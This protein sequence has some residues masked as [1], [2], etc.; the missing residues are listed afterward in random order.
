MSVTCQPVSVGIRFGLAVVA[1]LAPGTA[2]RAEGAAASLSVTNVPAKGRGESI[3]TVSRFGRYAV[4]AESKQGTALQL[5][6]RMLGPGEIKGER[7]KAN[8]RIDAILDRGTYKV[9]TWSHKKGTGK[10]TLKVHDFKELNAKPPALIDYKEVKATLEDFQQ[11]SYWIWVTSAQ[12]VLIEAVGRDLADLRLWKD[13]EWL[14]D[15][16]PSIETTQPVVGR[17]LTN[18]K[19]AVQLEPGLYLVTAYGGPGLA[20]A[21]ESREHPFYIRLN[22]PRLAS[23]GRM[24]LEVSPFGV[25]RFLVPGNADYFRIELPE[26][27]PAVLTVESSSTDPTSFGGRGSSTSVSKT[28]LPPVASLSTSSA[29]AHIVTVAAAPGQPYVLQFFE[30]NQS[31]S[32]SRHDLGTEVWLS[33]IHSG[34]AADSIDATGVIVCGRTQHDKRIVASSVI[35]LDGSRPYRRRFNL[36][37][38]A[39]LMFEVKEAGTYKVDLQ[40]DGVEATYRFQ[41]MLISYGAHYEVPSMQKSGTSWELGPGFWTL[42]MSPEKKGIAELTVKKTSG[43]GGLVNRLS[44]VPVS[45]VRA[46]A[47]FGTFRI[48]DDD[49]TVY[50][51]QQPGVVSGLDLRRLP[52]NLGNALPVVQLAGNNLKLAVTVPEAG[53]LVA[54]KEDGKGLPLSVDGGTPGTEV[55]VA[56]GSHTVEIRAEAAVTL[57]YSLTLKVTRLAREAPLPSLPDTSKNLIPKLEELTAHAPKF[58]DLDRHRQQTFLV[59]VQKPGLYRLESTGLLATS[60]NL[61]TRT[62]T[63]FDRE[64]QNGVGRNF[65]IQQYLREGDYQLTVETQGETRG[66]L[67]VELVQTEILDGGELSDGIVARARVP[68]SQAMLYRFKLSKGGSY[69]LRSFGIGRTFRARLEDGEGWPLERPGIPAEMSAWLEPGNYRFMLLPEAVDA[70]QLTRIDRA[71]KKTKLTGHGPHAVPLGQCA[72]NTWLEPKEGSQRK[73]DVW[74]FTLPAKATTRVSLSADMV[75][76]LTRVDKTGAKEE[77]GVI[78]LKHTFDQQL[79]AGHYE[80]EAQNARINNRVSYRACV[81]PVELLDGMSR[82]IHS[83]SQPLYITVD[84]P[85]LV[86]LASFGKEDVRASLW[87]AQDNLLGRSDDRTDDWNFHIAKA[88]VPGRY[89]LDIEPVGK[90]RATTV[91]EMRIPAEVAEPTLALPAQNEI[92]PGETVHL[93]PLGPLPASADLLITQAVARE[94]IGVSIERAGTGGTWI[95][96]GTDLGR[97]VHLEVPMQPG[98]TYRLRL[99]SLDRRGTPA[100]LQVVGVKTEVHGESE[101]PG[102]VELTA[103]PGLSPE[104]GVAAVDLRRTG[105]IKV[106][107]DAEALRWTSVINGAAGAT[108]DGVMPVQGT[109]LWVSNSGGKG[110]LQASRTILSPLGAPAVFDIPPASTARADLTVTNGPIVVLATSRL[111]QPGVAVLEAKESRPSAAKSMAVATRAALSVS[112]APREAVAEVWTATIAGEPLDVKLRAFGFAKTIPATDAAALSGRLSDS[113]AKA[114]SLSPGNKRIRLVADAGVVAVLSTKDQVLSTHWRGDEALDESLDTSADRLTWLRIDT[115][116]GRFSAQL[117][118]VASGEET[119]ALAMGAPFERNMTASGSYRLAVAPQTVKD[120]TLWIHGATADAVFVGV[121]GEVNRGRQIAVSPEG[122]VVS[123]P[124][125]ASWLIAYLQRGDDTAGSIWGTDRELAVRTPRPPD[126]LQLTGTR[127]RLKLEAHDATVFHLRAVEPMAARLKRPDGKVEADIYPD[128]LSLDVYVAS[129]SAEIALRALGSRALSSWLEVTTSPVATIGDGIGPEILLG[130]GQSRFFSF[131]VK[132]KGTIGVGVRSDSDRVAAELRDSQGHLLGTGV[133]QMPEVVPGTYL[134]AL[135]MARDATPAR[136]RPAVVGLKPPDT[137]PPDEIKRQYVATDEPSAAEFTARPAERRNYGFGTGRPPSES[138]E[139]ES[140]EGY[141]GE[142]NEPSDTAEGGEEGQPTESTEE[143][144]HDAE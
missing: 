4:T 13:G 129:G 38:P 97:R 19:L 128:G 93:F 29:S 110:K 65:L 81:L 26:A 112:L 113:E 84:K 60:G 1:L 100:K 121:N 11:L 78:P 122:G 119:L 96:A 54:V 107:G 139:N 30:Q 31:V 50:I 53:K 142:A 102:G 62:V 10:A 12:T 64:E 67:G 22:I 40:G 89:R 99:W 94:G 95:S 43:L 115:G 9:V 70:L 71:K 73:P 101:L 72:S 61:R 42:E 39:T 15:A 98:A 8:G 20:W 45:S 58:F 104:I 52:M 59:R 117:L 76:R 36:L 86:E 123:I 46:A 111:G 77:V 135:R 125:P 28:S 18:A 85:S 44:D 33:T 55:A 138:D 75:G 69:T 126:R 137:G 140:G 124:H 144:S 103:V 49:C 131:V 108:P 92:T 25:D 132:S 21:E 47:V 27:L 32:L 3:L 118:P 141:A 120:R 7:G 6:S 79:E 127:E 68:A 88:L 83:P 134:L 48:P 90:G 63:T 87:D 51:N 56:T 24:R 116:E 74:T 109:R 17:P 105:M 82:E 66:H 130:P 143:D 23:V 35:D 80:L 57:S 133:A 37:S 2:A 91:V 106:I 16:S 114:V 34:L 41:P 14:Y 5:L 136:V